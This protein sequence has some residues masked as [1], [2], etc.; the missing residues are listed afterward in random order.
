[1]VVHFERA[2]DDPYVLV[3]AER[4]AD[5]APLETGGISVYHAREPLQ[6]ALWVALVQSLKVDLA[7]Q[8]KHN[9]V[10]TR[11]DHEQ[12]SRRCFGRNSSVQRQLG[13]SDSASQLCKGV[14]D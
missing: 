11:V 7:P 9:L 8:I 5:G 13:P 12:K 2:L 1:M 14:G 6:K 10:H 3:P 4:Q